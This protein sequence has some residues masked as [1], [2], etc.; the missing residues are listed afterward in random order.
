MGVGWFWAFHYP[1]SFTRPSKYLGN[2][3]K[4]LCRILWRHWKGWMLLQIPAPPS[5]WFFSHP[6]QWQHLQ[7]TPSS[8]RIYWENGELWPAAMVSSSP[9]RQPS[10]PASSPRSLSWLRHSECASAFPPVQPWVWWDD[11][12]RVNY[13][14]FMALWHFQSAEC[15]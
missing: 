6:N 8:A 10:L 4:M 15:S 1:P 7:L 5:K 11:S 13:S 2:I 12:L 3:Q 9:S 14:L